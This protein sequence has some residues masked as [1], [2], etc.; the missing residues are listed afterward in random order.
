MRQ[1]E[2]VGRW[3]DREHLSPPS[4]WANG[5][6]LYSYAE[7]IA[8]VSLQMGP[9]GGRVAVRLITPNRTSRTTQRHLGLLRQQCEERGIFLQESPEKN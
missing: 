8:I 5:A 7:P 4:L 6:I 9:S 3:L 2:I 1:K